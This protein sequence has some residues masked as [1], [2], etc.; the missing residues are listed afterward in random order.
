[1]RRARADRQEALSWP[2]AGSLLDAGVRALERF[3]WG[4]RG[5]YRAGKHCSIDLLQPHQKH[6]QIAYLAALLRPRL[7]SLPATLASTDALRY[8]IATILNI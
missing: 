7:R 6:S 4:L 8:N 2:V 1:M 3:Y 5:R